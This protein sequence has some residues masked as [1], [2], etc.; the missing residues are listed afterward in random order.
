M[1]PSSV[2]ALVAVKSVMLCG[3]AGAGVEK[4]QDQRSADE[5]KETAVRSNRLPQHVKP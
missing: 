4:P 1:E 5:Q 2:S 3:I